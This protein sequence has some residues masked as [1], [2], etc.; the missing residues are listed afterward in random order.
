MLESVCVNVPLCVS[1][2]MCLCV[3]DNSIS[4]QSRN[5]KLEYIVG[6]EISWTS[7]KMGMVGSRSFFHLPQYKLSGPITQ[8]WY[9]LGSF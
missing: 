1:V 6:Y 7:L 9:K 8:I 3:H 4:N 5:I 2:C